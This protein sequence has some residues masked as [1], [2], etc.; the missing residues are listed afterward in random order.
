M[1]TSQLK[2]HVHETIL[3]MKH[4]A[5]KCRNPSTQ[6]TERCKGTS[7]ILL[8]CVFEYTLLSQAPDSRTDSGVRLLYNK[9]SVVVVVPLLGVTKYHV[10][11]YQVVFIININCI[12]ISVTNNFDR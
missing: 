2:I 6:V 8:D 4:S 7:T 12:E 5:L 11:P 3:I 1:F 10:L 9:T